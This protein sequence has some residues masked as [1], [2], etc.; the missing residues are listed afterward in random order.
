MK[1]R[2]HWR[3]RKLAGYCIMNVKQSVADKLKIECFWAPWVQTAT[4][5]VPNT[6][7]VR[8]YAW[9]MS[10]CI[11]FTLYSGFKFSLPPQSS[12]SLPVHS[13]YA[14]IYASSP[15]STPVPPVCGH[16]PASHHGDCHNVLAS[17]SMVPYT[18]VTSHYA[19][20]PSGLL[21]ANN[22]LFWASLRRSLTSKNR[23]TTDKPSDIRKYDFC[24]PDAE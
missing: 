23:H 5:D 24:S 3:Y 4:S 7:T 19:S 21:S 2:N 17:P 22:S 18:A 6:S 14:E 12:A 1:R 20:Q 8:Q 16:L 15:L 11:S 9:I 13:R 10:A